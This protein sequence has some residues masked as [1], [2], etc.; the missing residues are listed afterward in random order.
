MASP[1]SRGYAPFIRAFLSAAKSFPETA[2]RICRP[3][4]P[5]AL[6]CAGT[7]VC[8][9]DFVPATKSM[10]CPSLSFAFSSSITLV[11]DFAF[12]AVSILAIL[13]GHSSLGKKS[14]LSRPCFLSSSKIFEYSFMTL[15]AA[16]SLSALACSSA[17]TRSNSSA[18]TPYFAKPS[19]LYHASRSALQNRFPLAS[20]TT[21]LAWSNASTSCLVLIGWLCMYLSNISG[22]TNNTFCA[23]CSPSVNVMYSSM[24]FS[25]IG[26]CPFPAVD[27][28]SLLISFLLFKLIGI[29]LM[30]LP[31]TSLSSERVLS[32]WNSTSFI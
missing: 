22:F 18:S 16:A 29:P 9:R 32:I 31:F 25:S 1:L 10:C 3:I 6:I 21:L 14:P 5:S 13:W 11:T 26:F 28:S 20:C 8:W 27:F 2:P 17:M 19:V 7:Y 12:V 24:I 15:A 4:L 23:R 30:P